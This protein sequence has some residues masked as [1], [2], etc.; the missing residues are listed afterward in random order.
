[1]HARRCYMNQ[2]GVW[3]FSCWSWSDFIKYI[4]IIERSNWA[5]RPIISFK[6]YEDFDAFRALVHFPC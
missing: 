1:M 6:R 2:S 3:L 4:E 5:Q